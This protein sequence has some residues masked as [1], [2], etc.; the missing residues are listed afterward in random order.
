MTRPTR[1]SPPPFRGPAS[2]AGG[3]ARVWASLLFLLAL[4]FAAP[5]FAAPSM[6]RVGLPLEPPNLD[7]TS[8]AAGAVDEVLYGNVFEGLVRI[9]PR[10]DIQPALATSW[11]I[12]P[13]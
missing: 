3:E 6:L 12:T 4:L 2:P 5:A 10:G 11:E 7:P 9:G 1:H 13:D 8:G